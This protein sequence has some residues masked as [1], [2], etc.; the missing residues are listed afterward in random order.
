MVEENRL[1]SIEGKS[2]LDHYLL[3]GNEPIV[4]NFDILSWWKMNSS[5]YPILGQIAQD[6]LPIPVSTIASEFALVLGI[7][8]WIILRVHLLQKSLRLLFVLKTG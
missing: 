2:E 7:V 3:D 1:N 8:S 4:E 6:V 5:K